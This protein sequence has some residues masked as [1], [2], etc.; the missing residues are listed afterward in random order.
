LLCLCLA[1]FF[2]IHLVL[3]MVARA[4]APLFLRRAERMASYRPAHSAAM[5]LLGLRL[6]PAVLALA[7]V[8]GLCL[9]SFLSFENERGSEDAG[10]PFLAAAI[11]GGSVWAI[12]LARS[13]RAVLRSRHCA[14]RRSAF[15]PAE[16]ETVWLWEGAAPFVGL[17]GVLRPRIVVSRS[18]ERA[19]DA[20]QLAAALRH[21]RAHRES[22]DNFKRLLLLLAPQA[23][24]GLSLFQAVDRAWAR[25][26]EWAADDCAVA[27][28][29]ACSLPLA[30]ALVRMAKLGAAP[31]PSPLVSQFLPTGEN[32]SARVERLLNSPAPAA[33]PSRG[34]G[35]T[36]AVTTLAAPLVA[37]LVAPASLAAVHQLLERFMH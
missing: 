24:P 3:S 30:E 25:F 31:Q 7:A 22:A 35:R 33:S 37:P 34:Y 29:G 36:L 16:S 8:A 1:S 15:L 18:I 21:E 23:I 19:L 17:A 27:Q 6:F 14:P 4:L 11:L 20:G 12:S 13:F 9:P 10:L 2:L 28:D 26:A 5:L 32:I